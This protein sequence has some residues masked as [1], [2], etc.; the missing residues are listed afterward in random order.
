MKKESPR[1]DKSD[2]SLRAW[3]GTYRAQITKQLPQFCPRTDDTG[4]LLTVT[5]QWSPKCSSF[6]PRVSRLNFFPFLY[7]L[8]LHE[9]FTLNC[10]WTSTTF[11]KWI[12]SQQCSWIQLPVSAMFSDESTM[13]QVLQS[14]ATPERSERCCVCSLCDSR[15]CWVDHTY[16]KTL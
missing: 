3:E 10:G 1:K 11:D 2:L 8:G 15:H 7:H 4:F 16:H 5:N 13:G 6:D 9:Q 14:P 12:S